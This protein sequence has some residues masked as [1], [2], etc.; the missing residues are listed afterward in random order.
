M[1]RYLSSYGDP[2]MPHAD[3]IDWIEDFPLD[4]TRNYIQRVLENAVVYS[5]IDPDT[6]RSRVGGQALSDYLGGM[7]HIG[8]TLSR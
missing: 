2:R 4:E 3:V 7:D 1:N 5:R 6:N 8:P